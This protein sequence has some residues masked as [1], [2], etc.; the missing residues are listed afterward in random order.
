MFPLHFNEILALVDNLASTRLFEE[1][2]A[3]CKTGFS[4]TRRSDQGQGSAGKHFQRDV[5]QGAHRATPCVK[6]TSPR[7]A[8]SQAAN[9][10]DRL[11]RVLR[12]FEVSR[13]T[14]STPR[15]ACLPS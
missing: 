11:R 9:R 8:Q 3:S 1:H 15:G 12:S 4:T 14:R 7:I 13:H 2:E 10:H 6:N 5:A